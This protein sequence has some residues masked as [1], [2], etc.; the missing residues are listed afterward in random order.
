MIFTIVLTLIYDSILFL[1][2]TRDQNNTKNNEF[3][4]V[5]RQYKSKLVSNH[6]KTPQYTH[7]GS[8][9]QPARQPTIQPTKPALCYWCHR[10]MS[11]TNSP[12]HVIFPLIDYVQGKTI[13]MNQ[14]RFRIFGYHIAKIDTSSP[15]LFEPNNWRTSIRGRYLLFVYVI[16]CDRYTKSCIKNVTIFYIS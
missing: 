8:A 6:W 16:I 11:N 15:P 10:T 3:N 1:F 12:M 2:T 5:S 13:K 14:I 4:D 9:K 7:F